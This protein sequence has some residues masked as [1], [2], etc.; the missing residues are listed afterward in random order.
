M[1]VS[2]QTHGSIFVSKRFTIAVL[3][4][5]LQIINEFFIYFLTM[6]G[7]KS[8]NRFYT[9]VRHP[10]LAYDESF[11]SCSKLRKACSK[12]PYIFLCYVSHRNTTTNMNYIPLLRTGC[13]VSLEVDSSRTDCECPSRVVVQALLFYNDCRCAFTILYT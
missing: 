6:P 3:Q 8:W 10:L 11:N 12:A 9:F 4:S 2:E 1:L 7:Q 13:N 5:V